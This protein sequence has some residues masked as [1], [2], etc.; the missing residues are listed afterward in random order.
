MT[1]LTWLRRCTGPVVGV[2]AGAILAVGCGGSG[3]P[4]ESASRSGSD[5]TTVRVGIIPIQSVAPLYIG[6]K[7]GF[8]REEGL[9]IKP[10]TAQG[11]A[12]IL[13]A[14][15]SDKWQFGF[16]NTVSLMIARSK[17]LGV[18]IVA[19]GSSGA[20]TEEEASSG[21]IAGEGSGV[22]SVGSLAGKT[23]AVNT[24]KNIDALAVK[25]TLGQ[26]GVDPSAVD[27]VEVPF[28][29]MQNALEQGRIDAAMLNEPFISQA[30]SEGAHLIARPYHTVAPLL[31]VATWFTSDR[32]IQQR[33]EVVRAFQRAM[34]R[35]LRYVVENPDVVRTS[36]PTYTEIPEDVVAD[37]KLQTFT[38]E[39]N[40]ESIE[41]VGRIA[42]KQ[43]LLDKSPS[44]GD[45]VYGPGSE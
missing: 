22:T 45:L 10:Q 14:V 28:P 16:S 9:A 39:L 37:M 27:L 35:S 29:E 11:G 24:L 31:T 32:L 5:L 1:A 34:K 21:L 30:V 6:M 8:F 38:T 40:V 19:A 33:P 26:A 20:Q 41:K 3:E 2:L 15:V 13:P 36:V 43:G 44:I 17:G 4:A 42:T 18:K 25:Y 12:A 7:R 23:L